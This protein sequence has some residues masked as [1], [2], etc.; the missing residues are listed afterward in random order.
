MFKFLKSGPWGELYSKDKL[1][2]YQK[3]HIIING[4]LTKSLELEKWTS[5]GCPLSPLLFI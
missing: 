1:Y 5:Q 2:T 4:D 3:A